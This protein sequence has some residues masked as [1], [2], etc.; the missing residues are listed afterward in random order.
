M[1]IA[2]WNFTA[3]RSY[4]WVL[5]AA[6]A[7][8]IVVNTLSRP[9]YRKASEVVYKTKDG[10]WVSVFLNAVIETLSVLPGMPKRT[11]IGCCDRKTSCTQYKVVAARY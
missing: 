10:E 8:Q 9:F 4:C 6:Y 5:F 11:G 3:L 2:P 7:Q 1:I